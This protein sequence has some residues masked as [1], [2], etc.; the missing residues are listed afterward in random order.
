MMWDE[1]RSAAQGEPPEK[2]LQ[3]SNLLAAN[4]T[5]NS[6][7]FGFDDGYW[8]RI[9]PTLRVPDPDL[10]SREPMWERW[11]GQEAKFLR[12]AED[13]WFHV[14]KPQ[15]GDVIVDIGAGRGEDVYA[16]SRSVGAQGIVWAMEPHPVSFGVLERLCR[17]NGLANV[18]ALRIAC[19]TE[20]AELQ[21]ET[22]PVWESNYV[23]AGAPSETSFTVTGRPFDEVMDEHGIERID[24]LKMNIE[25]AERLA[26]PGCRRALARARFA[27]IC[28]H[29]F[30]ADRGEGEEFRTLAFV[31]EFLRDAGFEILTRDDPRYYVPYHVHAWRTA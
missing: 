21:I 17:W 7:Q 22:L 3:A 13:Y 15:P 26:L 8:V 25:G 30:R 31:K 2:V 28:A 10:F 16:F 19:T 18:R 29:D 23:R 4:H 9:T 11:T 20:P 27:C 1:I 6:L 12:D 14:Y 24:F 5:G